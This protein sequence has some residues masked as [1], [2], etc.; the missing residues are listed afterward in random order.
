MKQI[1]K[2][3]LAASVIFGMTSCLKDKGY[4]NGTTGHDLSSVPKII[5]IGFGNETAK[6]KTFALSFE[7]QSVQ[8]TVFYVRLA[9]AEPAAE[10]ITVTLDTTGTAVAL[11]AINAAYEP[12]PTSFYTTNPAGLSVVI[13]KGQ[14]EVPV[15]LTTNAIQFDPSTTYGIVYKIKSVSSSNYN[16]SGNYGT[17]TV[18]FGAKN[19]YD[20]IYRGKGYTFM[21]NT[22][23]TAPFLW[24]IDCAWD[25]NLTT[26]AGNK[27]AMDAKPV[28]RNGSII[29]FGGIFPEIVFDNN[30]NKVTAISPDGPGNAYAYGFPAAQTPT[31]D[32]RYDPATKTIYVSY[33]II[34]TT[35][36]ATDTLIYC[37]PRG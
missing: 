3:T 18:L 17:Y 5:E 22:N 15:V 9:A 30:T 35:W 14:R 28:F 10:D 20:G 37:G 29:F 11:A 6:S 1:L 32:S 26:T 13:P 33:N 4:D 34:N 12:L 36:Y 7:D 25:L 27:V 8:R 24:S 16:I 23:T 2:Y 19:K 21:G 31:Y